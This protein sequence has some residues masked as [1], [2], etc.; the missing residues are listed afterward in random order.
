MVDV[1]DA[2]KLEFDKFMV[3]LEMETD[4]VKNLNQRRFFYL[5]KIGLL[6]GENILI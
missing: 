5:D 4:T 3:P 1:S 2:F 6:D